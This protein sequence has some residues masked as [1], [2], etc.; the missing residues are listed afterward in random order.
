P[1]SLPRNGHRTPTTSEVP[2]NPPWL[3]PR[4]RRGGRP[5][6]ARRSG[7]CDAAPLR[8]ASRGLARLLLRCAAGLARRL[9]V[10]AL[11]RLSG[12]LRFRTAAAAPV[13]DGTLRLAGRLVC[14][15]LQPLR[16]ISHFDLL[17]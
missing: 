9:L 4:P 2:P 10:L 1:A 7:R 11:D 8:T 17:L 14:L 16:A 15:A 3:A 5:R 12:T 6:G 13:A